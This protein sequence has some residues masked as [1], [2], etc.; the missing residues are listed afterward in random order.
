MQPRPTTARLEAL[1]NIYREHQPLVR[2]VVIGRGVPDASV[3]DVVHD[4]FLAIHRRLDERPPAVPVRQWVVSVA[5]NVAFSYRRSAA[6]RKLRLDQLPPPEASDPS[7]AE[8]LDAR[9]A[10]QVVCDFLDKL[11]AAQ[12]EVFVL[13]HVQGL[14][15]SEVA[16][17]LGCSPN[18]V[19]SRL[20]LARAKFT[21]HFPDA[22]GLGDHA[23]LL[24]RAARGSASTPSQ[25]R[26]NLALILGQVRLAEASGTG[27]ALPA[28][29]WASVGGLVAAAVIG[30][31]GVFFGLVPSSSS[32]NETAVVSKAEPSGH[33]PASKQISATPSYPEPGSSSQKVEFTPPQTAPSRPE[34]VRSRPR[35]ASGHSIPEPTPLAEVPPD[36]LAQQARQLQIVRRSLAVGQTLRAAQGLRNHAR[37]Y[38]E[39]PL[40]RER[41]RLEITL[42]C[43][44][45]QPDAAVTLAQSLEGIQ[46]PDPICP[47]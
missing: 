17:M 42:L 46:R 47:E 10:W 25:K 31:V 16:A 40:A 15:A 11:P 39:S 33:A 18:T 35:I 45:G 7:S 13:C 43:V 32:P 27:G 30:L 6:R 12:R 41:K 36:D 14:A 2:A 22:D 8:L 38:P 1:R 21:R 44:Q 37:T 34:P 23:A 28:L 19:G 3:D 20:R 26:R 5:R 29:G 9:R 24:R 4:S